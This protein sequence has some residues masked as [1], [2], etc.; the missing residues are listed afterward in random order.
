VSGLLG[1]AAAFLLAA[2]DPGARTAAAAVP[3]AARAVVLG[4]L[5]DAAPLAAAVALTLRAPREPALVAVWRPGGA[6][7]VRGTSGPPATRLAARLARRGMPATARG[8]LAW[9]ALEPEPD[10]ARHAVRRAA[11]AVDGPLVTALAGSRPPALEAL[12]DEHD[13]AIVAVEP[14]TPLARSALAALLD[15]CVS[16]IACPP[17]PRG[18]ARALSLAGIAAPRLPITATRDVVR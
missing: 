13:L 8:R 17:L 2:P 5:Q 16:A 4:T 7:P 12:I 1:R 9:L 14:D 11:A 18:P 6:D 3:A 10:A 15:R